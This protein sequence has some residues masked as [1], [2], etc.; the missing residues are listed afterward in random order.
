MLFPDKSGFNG[1]CL[2]RFVF[3]GEEKKNLSLL[4]VDIPTDSLIPLMI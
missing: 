1:K 3:R 2:G 4:R